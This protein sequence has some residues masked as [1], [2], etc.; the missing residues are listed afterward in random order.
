MRIPVQIDIQPLPHN[1]A[2]HALYAKAGG[3]RSEAVMWDFEYT[4]D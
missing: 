1:D 4:A 2:A 3:T